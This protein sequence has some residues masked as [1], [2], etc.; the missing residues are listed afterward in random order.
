MK[1]PA[2]EAIYVNK[3]MGEFYVNNVLQTITKK[4]II[5]A[6]NVLIAQH[7]FFLRLSSTS[8]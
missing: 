3:D 6:N 5:S 2:K 8:Y 4:I 7:G 1:E